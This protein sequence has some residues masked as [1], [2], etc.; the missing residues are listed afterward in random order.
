MSTWTRH[1]TWKWC[2]R[3][4]GVHQVIITQLF[5]TSQSHCLGWHIG[6]DGLSAPEMR[7]LPWSLIRNQHLLGNPGF[8]KASEASD[9]VMKCIAGVH[10]SDLAETIQWFCQ[11]SSSI[12]SPNNHHMIVGM[13]HMGRGTSPHWVLWQQRNRQSKNNK[14][15]KIS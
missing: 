12:A 7:M 9:T 10:Q 3:T 4:A 13:F 5:V 14:L 1:I 11:L 15:R 6:A 2:W 8:Y